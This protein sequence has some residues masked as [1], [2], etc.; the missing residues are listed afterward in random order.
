MDCFSIQIIMFWGYLFASAQQMYS[1]IISLLTVGL[2]FHIRNQIFL[3]LNFSYL[4]PLLLLVCDSW[5]W[6]ELNVKINSI[7]TT[8]LYYSL[9]SYNPWFILVFVGAIY[10]ATG[11]RTN[12]SHSRSQGVKPSRL[13]KSRD[14]P[15][16]KVFRKLG[17]K[18]R[19]KRNL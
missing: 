1:V 16:N 5:Y 12:H 19:K 13:V 18:P 11:W 2:T 3:D 7:W 9:I 4:S 17:R 14:W 15:C 8:T 10:I 6:W